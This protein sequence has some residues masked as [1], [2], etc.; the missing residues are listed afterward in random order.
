[1][2]IRKK[3]VETAAGEIGTKGTGRYG[4]SNK[5][6]TWFYGYDVGDQKLDWCVVFVQWVFSKA[7]TMH[8][9]AQGV[10]TAFVPYVISTAK[11][12]K[13]FRTDAKEV[14]PGDL[15]VFDF[16]G[17]GQGDHIGIV[18]KVCASYVQTIEGNVS[19]CVAR[20]NRTYKNIMG[21]CLMDIPEEDEKLEYDKFAEYMDVYKEWRASLPISDWAKENFEQ[22]GTAA[23]DRPRDYATREEVV[24]FILNIL[25][26]RGL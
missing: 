23:P 5:Y 10:K 11:R 20:K 13:K 15:I 22:A 21:Y 14:R 6:N 7:Y 1:M 2:N 26:E 19:K 4:A 9:V 16:N 12:L 18:E 3:I 25:K 24:Q 17:N 8:V